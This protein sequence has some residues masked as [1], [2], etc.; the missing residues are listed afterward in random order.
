[1]KQR[2]W[3]TFTIDKLIYE[4]VV[5]EIDPY[6]TPEKFLKENCL[7]CRDGHFIIPFFYTYRTEESFEEVRA[8]DNVMNKY[9]ELEVID[10]YG[11][12]F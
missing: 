8:G 10:V 11:E 6:T 3:R 9:F 12:E 4:W 2:V 7:P 1:M 5:Q